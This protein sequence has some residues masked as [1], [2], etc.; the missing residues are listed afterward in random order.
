ML[1]RRSASLT[2][3]TRT[4][5]EIASKQLAQVFR[6]LGL[7]GDEIELLDL[8]QALDQP[9]DV[10]AEEFVDLGARRRRVLDRI[11]QQGDGDGRLVEMHVGQDGGDFERMGDIGI[12]A[13]A[14]LLPMLLHGIDIGLVQQSFIG[15][16]LVF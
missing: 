9:A 5:S 15:I 10:L 16:G 6:L 4:S 14:L 13:G 8:R 2:R 12:A 3:S 1:C 11:V 7:L